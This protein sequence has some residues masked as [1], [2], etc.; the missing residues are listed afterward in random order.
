MLEA[1]HTTWPGYTPRHSWDPHVVWITSRVWWLWL[2]CKMHEETSAE[3]SKEGRDKRV[4]GAREQLPSATGFTERCMGG[5][6][7]QKINITCARKEHGSNRNVGVRKWKGIYDATS[8]NGIFSLIWSPNASKR[9]CSTGECSKIR[10][11]LLKGDLVG[12]MQH[13]SFNTP[14]NVANIEGRKA[15]NVISI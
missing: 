5:L 2:Y 9:G 11:T 13:Q 8:T 14:L 15:T 4:H 7:S 10:G 1:L 12:K 3:R 6:D